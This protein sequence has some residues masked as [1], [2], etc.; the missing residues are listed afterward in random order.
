M[1]KIR[2]NLSMKIRENS[3]KFHLRG[4]AAQTMGSIKK[5]GIPFCSPQSTEQIICS[6][7]LWNQYFLSYIAYPRWAEICKNG[8]H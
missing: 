1:A 7:Q 3:E 5:L 8:Y 6:S 2:Q 4:P